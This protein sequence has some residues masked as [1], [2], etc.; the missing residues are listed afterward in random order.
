MKQLPLSTD[1][2][3][4]ALLDAVMDDEWTLVEQYKHDLMD[5]GLTAADVE[6][7][8]RFHRVTR[9]RSSSSP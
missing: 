2:L 7:V 4:N 9:P 6:Y 8:V 1:A 5:R 3:W